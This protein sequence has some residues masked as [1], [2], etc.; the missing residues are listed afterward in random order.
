MLVYNLNALNKVNMI[1][2]IILSVSIQSPGNAW[3]VT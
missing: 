2:L 1:I 3:T